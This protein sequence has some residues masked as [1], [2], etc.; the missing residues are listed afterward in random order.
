MTIKESHTQ[1]F[2]NETKIIVEI[3]LTRKYIVA[4]II[5]LLKQQK[6]G[7]QSWQ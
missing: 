3:T 5:L 7:V 4:T 6:K 2:Y 1:F